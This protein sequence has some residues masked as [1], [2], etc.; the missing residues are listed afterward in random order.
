M[1]IINGG[2]FGQDAKEI[3]QLLLDN[4]K[5]DDFVLFVP[6]ATPR[7]QEAYFRFFQKSMAN[8]GLTNVDWIDLY[9]D[10]QDKVK[11]AKA[12]YLAGGNTFKLIDIMRKSGFDKYLKEVKDVIIYGNSAGAVVL[13]QNISTTNDEDIIGITD[14]TGLGMLPCCIGAHYTEDKKER[15]QELANKYHVKIIAVPEKGGMLFNSEE[16]RGGTIV[17]IM[18]E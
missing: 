6:A 18:P 13:G 9:G 8:Y 14:F 2:C 3:D 17:E 5:T 16:K 10:W 11:G 1:I 15:L 4:I 12:I 7:S